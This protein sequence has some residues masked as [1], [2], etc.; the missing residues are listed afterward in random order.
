MKKIQK[1]LFPTDFSPASSNA[2]H[3]SLLFADQLEAEIEV[4]HVIYPQYQGTDLPVMAAKATQE[5]IKGVRAIMENFIDAAVDMVTDELEHT[6]TIETMIELGSPVGTI[7]AIAERD[8]IDLVMMGTQGEHST[9]EKLFGSVTSGVI[10]RTDCH[11]LA[12]PEHAKLEKIH[13]MAFAT[14]LKEADPYHIWEVTNLLEP[15]SPILHCVHLQSE[16]DVDKLVEMTD[17][18]NFFANHAPTLQ[19]N[20]HI[21]KGDCLDAQLNEFA[22]TR[23]VDLLVMASPHRSFFE[24]LFHRSQT[25]RMALNGTVPL[26]IFRE[27]KN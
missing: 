10:Q 18:E 3:Y 22:E 9:W 2:F 7:Q 5:Q 20:F 25:R 16:D 14:N 17:M 23:D 21:L 26:F 11:I 1:I 13:T 4:L 6:A 19:I 12:I 15:F 8:D 27:D 24:R